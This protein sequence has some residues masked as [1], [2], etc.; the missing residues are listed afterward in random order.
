MRMYKRETHRSVL[1]LSCVLSC[2]LS[3]QMS[4][5]SSDSSSTDSSSSSSSSSSVRLYDEAGRRWR[6]FVGVM[7]RL[8]VDEGFLPQQ[9]QDVIGMM[10]T[11]LQRLTTDSPD[12]LIDSMQ[13]ISMSTLIRT[14]SESDGK[15]HICCV[16]VVE[17]KVCECNYLICKTCICKL[18]FLEC[19]H[20]RKSEGI[21]KFIDENNLRVK[22]KIRDTENP[23]PE[24]PQVDSLIFLSDEE[25]Q[26]EESVP[27]TR[28]T[29]TRNREQRNIVDVEEKKEDEEDEED[30]E[31]EAEDNEQEEQEEDDDISS[32][33]AVREADDQI[34]EQLIP[35][36]PSPE[37]STPSKKG[38]RTSSE[39]PPTPAKTQAD[40]FE[41]LEWCE[42][43]C[44][45]KTID[46][47]FNDLSLAI[48]SCSQGIDKK[49]TS[50]MEMGD[51]ITEINFISVFMK[52][53]KQIKMRMRLRLG[54]LYDRIFEL[55]TI[56]GEKVPLDV[57]KMREDGTIFMHR[58]LFTSA[59][60]FIVER[61]GS[62]PADIHYCRRWASLCTTFPSLI[63]TEK[64][65]GWIKSTMK[66]K[67]LDREI[68]NYIIKK[69]SSPSS[70]SSSSSSAVPVSAI[71]VSASAIPVPV[72]PPY[73]ME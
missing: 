43:K 28:N 17:Y 8:I 23:P 19:G 65:W 26:H 58:R 52:K 67:I 18:K 48:D 29:R 46:E 13:N 38:R 40:I 49:N 27:S 25:E 41:M 61:F 4:S 60:T 32:V 59:N 54:V 6:S 73:A 63:S 66:D 42:K 24:N 16:S 62:N 1:S 7:E 72:T 50:T 12:S 53:T 3:F 70:A 39:L 57:P 10:S 37:E 31:Q 64:S 47:L 55:F 30:N 21:L 2:V 35:S 5:S 56:K 34:Q 71:P 36:D 15:C 51:V 22:G 44:N 45:E 33:A 68:E 9:R 20:C 11:F 14:S 69:N